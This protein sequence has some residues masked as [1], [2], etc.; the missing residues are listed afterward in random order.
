VLDTNVLLDWLV[1]RNGALHP[2]VQ[3]LQA[4]RLRWIATAAMRDEFVHVVGRGLGDR[5]VIDEA[6]WG[7]AWAVQ[8]DLVEA[9]AAPLHVPR[10]TDRDDQK[11]IDLAVVAGAR[12]LL[13]RDRALLKLA[14][15][16][17]R[18]GVE[19]LTPEAWCASAPP[20]LASG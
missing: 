3:A 20:V 6:A 15:R 4:R 11:F 16:S 12:W 1:F 5:W 13:T 10:C 9:A 19:V 7:A 8:A 18:Y 17:R 2:L 14:R